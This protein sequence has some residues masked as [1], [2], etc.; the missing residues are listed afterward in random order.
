[1]VIIESELQY[2]NLSMEHAVGPKI[3]QEI[4]VGPPA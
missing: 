2:P 1:M 4:A 3:Q